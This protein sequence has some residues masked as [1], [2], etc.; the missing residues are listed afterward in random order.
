MKKKKFKQISGEDNLRIRIT[1][2]DGGFLESQSVEANLLYAIL[3]KTNKAV[4][5][6]DAIRCGG[7]DIENATYD[8]RKDQ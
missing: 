6:L 7:I 4:E 2:K 8:T 5:L 1:D 3:D